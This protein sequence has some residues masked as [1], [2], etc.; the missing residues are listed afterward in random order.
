M[1]GVPLGRFPNKEKTMDEKHEQRHKEFKQALASVINKFSIDTD[2][3]TPDF[4]L[5]D[6]CYYSLQT[7]HEAQHANQKW[8]DPNCGVEVSE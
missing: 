3:S 4:I 5:A 2:C 1:T 8:H 6:V 7:F